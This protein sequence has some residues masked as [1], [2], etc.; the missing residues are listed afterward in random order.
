M[1]N[2]IATE[3]AILQKRKFGN[4]SFRKLDTL[5]KQNMWP[6]AFTPQKTPFDIRDP[7]MDTSLARI[8]SSIGTVAL[9][10]SWTEKNQAIFFQL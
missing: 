9:K 6:I 1:L 3:R 2:K 7:I 5:T 4:I 8:V 10:L